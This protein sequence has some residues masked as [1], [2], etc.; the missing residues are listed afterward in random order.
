MLAKSFKFK[1]HDC[2]KTEWSGFDEFKSVNVIIGRNNTGKS[3]LLDVLELLTTFELT[4]LDFVFRCEGVLDETVLRSKFQDRSRGGN[5][6]G[7]RNHWED[8]GIR[9]VGQEV[10][11]QSEVGG[12]R[13]EMIRLEYPANWPESNDVRR[14]RIEEAVAKVNAPIYMRKFR[15]LLADRDVQPEPA[16]T[17]LTLAS[18]GDGATNIIRRFVLAHTPEMREEI[19]Q[20]ELLGALS[21]IFGQDGDFERIELRHHEESDLWE[22]FLG[23][24]KKGLVA[25]SRSGSGLKTVILV[26]LN[27]LVVPILKKTKLSEYVFAFEELENILPALLRRLLA[28]LADFVE[29]EKCMLF[30]T[31]HSNVTLDYLGTRHDTQIIHVRHDG[32]TASTKT[33]AAHFDHVGLLTELGARPSD[34]LQANGV[35]WLEGPS[36]R[37]YFNRF[38]ELF[39]DGNLREGRDYQCAFYGGSNLANSTF[40]S[41]DESDKTFANLLRLNH[42]VAIVCDGDRT[43]AAGEGSRIKARVQRIKREAV[44]IPSSYLWITEAKEIENYIPGEVWA[45]V[46]DRA[47]VADPGPYDKF[48]TSK[49]KATDFVRKVLGRKSFDK[50]DFAMQAVPH[51]TRDSLSTRFDMKKQMLDLVRVIEAWNQ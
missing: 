24:P 28:Y 11:W 2:F 20:V 43:A 35:I 46:Y 26:L 18:D 30:L 14:N 21:Q 13:V 4:K 31:T 32:E 9:F 44:E 45:K 38:I 8:H 3:Q 5:L 1:G 47:T 37:I 22:V 15:R 49:L 7:G 27:L 12:S 36:D 17:S 10:E 50:C 6:P 29:R 19:I 16:S 34:L 48:P 39:S 42:N 25:L 33:I 51:L 41:P 23:E 40:T